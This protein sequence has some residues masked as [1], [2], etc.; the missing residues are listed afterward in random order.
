MSQDDAEELFHYLMR[1]HSIAPD[2]LILLL[3]TVSSLSS[4]KRYY[5]A[6]L[7]RQTLKEAALVAQACGWRGVAVLR[8]G[9]VFVDEDGALLRTDVDDRLLRK[10]GISQAA[11][12]LGELH[13]WGIDPKIILDLGANLGEISIYFAHRLPHARVVAFEPAPENLAAF[14]RN[15]A[16]Q[17]RPLVNLELIR[18][19]VSDRSGQIEFIAG[20]GDLNTAMV[21]GNLKRLKRRA[22]SADVV[23][24][25]SDTLE[26]YCARLGIGD[27]DFL[28]I[29]IEGGEPLLGP[30]IARMAGRIGAAYVE[31][32][33]FNSLEAYVGLVAAFD[34]AGL[35]MLVDRVPVQNAE[36]CFREALAA[37]SVINVWFVRNDHLPPS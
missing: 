31:I 33:R 16:V 9:E 23:K 34:Q 15:L 27:I 28:K 20:A 19:A 18:E 8:D 10:P 25:P 29:D 37:K 6:A 17:R 24:V 32:S 12:M 7:L 22:K 36:A 11:R 3:K 5:Q 21:E 35:T 13:A 14:D 30:S 2:D 4:K 26:N 1:R